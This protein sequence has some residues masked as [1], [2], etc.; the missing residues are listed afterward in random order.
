MDA[1]HKLLLLIG[2]METKACNNPTVI[3][4]STFEEFIAD[5]LV[6]AK[7]MQPERSTWEGSVDCQ[8]GSF[9]PDEIDRPWI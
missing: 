2:E 4:T 9:R 3:K 5:L 8:G 7:E 6:I 1:R